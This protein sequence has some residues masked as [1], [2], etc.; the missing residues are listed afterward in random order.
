MSGLIILLS[1]S[2]PSFISG[3]IFFYITVSYAATRVITFTRPCKGKGAACSRV[4]DCT[5]AL[6]IW[7]GGAGKEKKYHEKLPKLW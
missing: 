5:H 1:S 2:F 7:R 4:C 6:E 3:K